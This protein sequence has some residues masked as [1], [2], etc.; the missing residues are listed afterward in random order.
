VADFPVSLGLLLQLLALLLLL[1]LLVHVM[2]KR[3]FSP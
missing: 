3:Y 1:W 2:L